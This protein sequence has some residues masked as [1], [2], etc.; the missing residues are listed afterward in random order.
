MKER[1]Q[2]YYDPD[3][4]VQVSALVEHFDEIG[5]G[6]R[7]Y[8]TDK[9]KECLKVYQVLA[10]RCGTSEPMDVLLHY[11]DGNE[12]RIPRVENRG[13]GKD[14]AEKNKVSEDVNEGVADLLGDGEFEFNE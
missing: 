6:R 7:G 12:S 11:I 13:L 1:L 14:K 3:V 10:E 2:V 8:T 4:D 9:L 5:K